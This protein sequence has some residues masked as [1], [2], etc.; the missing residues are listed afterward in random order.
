MKEG[1]L[2][3]LTGTLY[4]VTNVVV[5]HPFDTIKTKMQAQT[6]H[7]VSQGKGPSYLDCIHKTFY[8]E[9]GF[10]A[11]Y[12]GSIPPMWGSMLFRSLQFS[13]FEMIYTACEKN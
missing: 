3:T 11:F 9:G 1:L 8:E 7:M 2:T 4:G 6:S 10:R 5:G 12:K 13:V